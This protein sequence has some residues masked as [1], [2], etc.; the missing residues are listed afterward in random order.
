LSLLE[1]DNSEMIQGNTLAKNQTF[2]ESANDEPPSPSLVRP[3][4]LIP[5][6]GEEETLKVLA[7]NRNE[8]RKSE[9]GIQAFDLAAHRNEVIHTEEIEKKLVTSEK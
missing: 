5:M 9:I 3:K 7:V 1:E 8:R 2:V 6:K 4:K